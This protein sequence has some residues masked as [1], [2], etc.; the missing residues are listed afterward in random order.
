MIARIVIKK[1]TVTETEH[2]KKEE[3]GADSSEKAEDKKDIYDK[4]GDKEIRQ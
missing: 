2:P 3:N 1:V 4:Q